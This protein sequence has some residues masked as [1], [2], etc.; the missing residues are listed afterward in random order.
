MTGMSQYMCIPLKNVISQLGCT[1]QSSH[2]NP[3]NFGETKHTKFITMSMLIIN[4]SP[5]TDSTWYVCQICAFL[6]Q[7]E[8]F[9]Y[10]KIVLAY[11]WRHLGRHCATLLQNVPNKYDSPH[12]VPNWPYLPRLPMLFSKLHPWEI[13][14]NL[15]SFP[16]PLYLVD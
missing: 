5:A 15:F 4:V 12:L 10:K 9:L 8:S 2:K 13:E 6:T 1:Y 11:N 16:L 14:N 7:R 3:L